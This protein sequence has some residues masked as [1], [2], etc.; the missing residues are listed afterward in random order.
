[1]LRTWCSVLEA[2]CHNVKSRLRIAVSHWTV[3]NDSYSVHV[4]GYLSSPNLVPEAQKVSG[5][6]LIPIP[7]CKL[8]TLVLPSL[9]ESA[10]AAAE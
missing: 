8:E 2:E 9:K 5:E 3:V 4:V 1:M 7:W 10:A 6:P